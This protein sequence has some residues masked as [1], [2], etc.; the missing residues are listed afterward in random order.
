MFYKPDQQTRNEARKHAITVESYIKF[1]KDRGIDILKEDCYN[2]I[3][4]ICDGSCQGA[5]DCPIAQS[6]WEDSKFPTP[7]QIRKY[8]VMNELTKVEVDTEVLE[9]ILDEIFSENE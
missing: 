9:S 7:Y 8:N 1:F 3:K 6:F 5:C 4:N 2:P